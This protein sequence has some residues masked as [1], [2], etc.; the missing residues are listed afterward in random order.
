MKI[1]DFGLALQR[2]DQPS[3]E[4]PTVAATAQGVV[5]GT[6]GY[7]SPEQVTGERVDARSDIFALGCVLYEMMSGRALFTGSTPQE[8]IARLLHDSVPELV[9]FDPLAPAELRPILLALRRPGHDAPL[10][11]GPGRGDG[12]ARVADGIRGR[13]HSRFETTRG[14]W[15]V[16]G[17][18]AVRQCRHRSGH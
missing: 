15:Q 9:A 16:A 17:R 10:R 2:L 7:M 8:V 5:L 13:R 6:F 4:G 1:L 3:S 18:V 12:A 14:P 11:I